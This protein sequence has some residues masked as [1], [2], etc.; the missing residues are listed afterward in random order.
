MVFRYHL[1]GC[2]EAVLF[3]VNGYAVGGWMSMEAAMTRIEWTQRTWNP[4]VGCGITSPGCTNCYAMRMASRLAAFG[5]PQYQGLTHKVKGK[6]VWTGKVRLA[7]DHKLHEPL[8]VKRPT[9][10][11]VN[12]MS[13]LFHKDV[14][15][16]WIRRVIAVMAETPLHTYQVL[17]KRPDVAESFFNEYGRIWPTNAWLGVSVES[18][19]WTGRIDVL[20]RLPAR[21]R[22]LSVEPLIGPVGHLNLDDIHWVITGGE[23][24]PGARQCRAEWV[25][26]VRDQCVAQGKAFFHKQWGGAANNPLAAEKPSGTPLNQWIR[27]V[28][29]HGKGGAMLD[30]RLWREYPE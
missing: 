5:Q 1:V 10:W 29:P 30:G 8:R 15:W 28:D 12:S 23:S 3:A 2:L 22:F 24:G 19:D 27:Q 13:D 14:E 20:R 11:F 25:R 9:V 7:S 6:S 21:I 26:E 17:T 4:V 18:A 16:D